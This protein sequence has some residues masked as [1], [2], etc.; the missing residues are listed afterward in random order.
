MAANPIKPVRCAIYTRK[1][2]EHG[3]EQE[4]NSLHAQRDA[5]EAYIKSQASQGWRAL[6][7]HYDDPAY[8]GGNLDR[9]AL[10]KL[11]KDID[12][13]RI[14][15]I[16]VYKID[17][18]TRSLADFAKLVEAFDAKSISFVAV[19]QQFNTTTSMGRL[20][21]NILLSFA[22]F[23]RELSSERV[24]DK[25]AASRRKGKWT[26]GT[27]PLGYDAKDKKLVI[28]KAEAETVRYIFKRYLELQSFGKL[29]EDL[30]K[31]GVVTKRRDTK[32]ERWNGGIPFT[33]G[34]LA[35][36]LK[37]RLYIG[38]T[39]H[40][41]KWFPGE[42]AAIVDRK[43]FDQVQR[44]LAS[45]S[46]SRKTT[47]SASEA[48]LIG[49]LYDDRDNLMSPSYSTKNGIR[50]RF[51]VS[52]ALL[53]GRKGEVGSVGRVP[54]ALIE[55]AIVRIVRNHS[56]LDG[57]IDDATMLDRHLTR[58]EL[59]KKEVTLL[60]HQSGLDAGTAGPLDKNE[61]GAEGFNIRLPWSSAA[62]LQAASF[63]DS[64]LID[65]KE[66]DPKMVQTIV[67]ALTW[68]A[69]LTNDSYASVEELAATANLHPKVVRN[70]LKLAYLAPEIVEAV[71]SGRQNFSLPDLRDLSALSWHR[72]SQALNRPRAAD[73]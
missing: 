65:S 40:K 13:G 46:T 20:T 3:L 54:A 15:V 29:V 69:A 10:Q 35:H 64:A 19:T 55:S 36:F 31:S 57:S 8:S 27:V 14:D 70:E 41:D 39:G 17:R 11:L 6:P 50:Y 16:V 21:L 67:R 61:H 30:D 28:N 24:R 53:R 5:C 72:Q 60:L 38:E 71:L 18:L 32:V 49:K 12:A 26:G 58:V 56:R 45:K 62:N 9:P 7:Q 23:E 37:N 47:R 33:Y 34:P 48:L 22:Q 4:F 63:D 1:S 25:V 51:Y 59:A 43:T 52:S 2:T 68:V 44:L 73:K 66:P 42:H